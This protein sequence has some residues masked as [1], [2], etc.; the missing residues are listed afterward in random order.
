MGTPISAF[1]I[2]TK[3]RADLPVNPLLPSDLMVVMR[4]DGSF[5]VASMAWQMS[6]LDG[7]EDKQIAWYWEDDPTY[8]GAFRWDATNG[9]WIHEGDVAGQMTGS[10]SGA[11]SNVVFDENLVIA[12]NTVTL[13]FTPTTAVIVLLSNQR[14]LEKDL[15][16]TIVGATLTFTSNANV[17]D[18]DKI[19]AIYGKA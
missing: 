1:P 7:A 8:R 15:D 3:N 12:S 16:F 2:Q 19:N 17:V 14:P 6:L 4:A 18:G 10:G 11:T 9:N 13:N 5:G